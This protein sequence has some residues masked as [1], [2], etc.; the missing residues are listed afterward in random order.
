MSCR[1]LDPLLCEHVRSSSKQ[2]RLQST[3]LLPFL[4][5]VALYFLLSNHYMGKDDTELQELR[6]EDQG[7]DVSWSHTEP[8]VWVGEKSRKEGRISPA[9]KPTTVLHPQSWGGCQRFATQQ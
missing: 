9:P 8:I 3:L 2:T 1:R 7:L 5:I 4:G 6:Q